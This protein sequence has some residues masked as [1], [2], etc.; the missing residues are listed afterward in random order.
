MLSGHIIDPC[1]EVLRPGDWYRSSHQTI[2][3]AIVSLHGQGLPTDAIA[4]VNRLTETG[5]LD[6]ANGAARIHELAAL[7]PAAGNAPHYARIIRELAGFRDLIRVG[8][9]TARRGWD[10][11]GPLS[12]ALDASEQEMFALAHHVT[13][14][15][16]APVGADLQD[17]YA[18]LQRLAEDGNA[19]VGVASGLGALDAKTA[20]FQPGNLIVVGARPSM[21]KSALVSGFCSHVALRLKRPVALFTLEMTRREVHQR[22]IAIEGLVDLLK[23]RNGQL[24][25]DE[26]RRVTN[27]M[28]L[29]NDA[30]LFIEDNSAITLLEVRSQARKLAARHP[31][32]AL[33]VVDYLQLLTL[34]TKAE[35]RTQ[36]VS[37]LSRGL[38]LLAGELNVPVIALSQLNRQVEQRHDKRPLMSDLRECVARGQ[39]V[40]DPQT[41]RWCAIE[42]LTEANTVLGLTPSFRNATS[43]IEDVWSTGYKPVLRLKT[44]SGR[45][46]VATSNHPLLTINGW[47]PLAAVSVGQR[48]AAS[49]VLPEPLNPTNK[50]TRD[51]VRLLGYLISDG[52]YAKWRCVSYTKADEELLSEVEDICLRRFGIVAKRQNRGGTTY[53]MD[54]TAP[55][56]GPGG[57][58]LINWLKD[59]GIHGQLGHDK[60]FPD[61][62]WGLDND[63]LANLIAT[64]WAG[65]GT[66]TPHENRWVFKFT[67]T[68]RQLLVDLQMLLLRF[69]VLSKVGP[70]ERNTKST[71][72]IATLSV[73]ERDAQI[74]FASQ[75]DLPGEKGVLLKRVLDE[76]LTR[77]GRNARI[78]RLPIEITHVVAAEAKARR[79]GKVKLGYRPQ[80]KEMCR[81]D[82]GRVSL[83]LENEHLHN[84]ATSDVL[85]DEV[86]SIED[87]GIQETFDLRAPQTGNFLVSGLFC[88]NSGGVEADAD[89]ICLLYRDAAYHP[90][91]AEE[92]GTAGTAEINIAKHRNGPTD[93]ITVAFQEKYARFGDLAPSW[94]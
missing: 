24:N 3:D 39:K 52:S 29:L 85:W 50:F 16:L 94:R 49:R 12:E 28:G 23:L 7:V 54:L 77:E 40:Y 5:M 73:S 91:D 19:I 80:G 33:V 65:D 74:A 60:T 83:L 14:S 22:L 42:T 79:W 48:I 44:K 58:P 2:W 93:V 69:G 17:T 1:L 72:D 32:L 75:F 67:S 56:R 78:D 51:E 81:L 76:L 45:E 70:P 26:W 27:T 82:L 92:M 59:I 66:I 25:G 4:V 71:K 21:G 37:Q 41:G 36:E 31:D 68:S 84:L 90:E 30:P 86:V 61:D 87:A 63:L 35:N 55:Q 34:G 9:E 8:T 47:E 18:E 13:R 57:N 11:T 64:L 46:L 43:E 38:K 20:G 53:D 10:R 15:E 89:V 6:A 62:I 88:H